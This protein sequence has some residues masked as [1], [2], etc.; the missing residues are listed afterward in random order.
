[1]HASAIADI[2][3]AG[4]TVWLAATAVLGLLLA[5]LA[6]HYGLTP[7]APEMRQASAL[8]LAKTLPPVFDVDAELAGLL[9]RDPV[10]RDLDAFPEGARIE[11]LAEARSDP[12]NLLAQLAPRRAVVPPVAIAGLAPPAPTLTAEE[13]MVIDANAERR[14]LRLALAD[15]RAGTPVSSVVT[16]LVAEPLLRRAEV[17]VIELDGFGD[18]LLLA[19]TPAMK[20]AAWAGFDAWRFA[21]RRDL[22]E[23][24]AVLSS[25]AA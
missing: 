23:A 13:Q 17:A 5:G 24:A 6:L 2:A 14:E 10:S 15:L 7:S 12:L 22:D 4:R 3:S 19:E 20:Q 16:M 25:N 9:F 18:A 8:R 1:M 11:R 21:A